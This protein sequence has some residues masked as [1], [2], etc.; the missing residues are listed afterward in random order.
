MDVTTHYF[1]LLENVSG[2]SWPQPGQS[3]QGEKAG[4]GGGWDEEWTVPQQERFLV[5]GLMCRQSA[6]DL[7]ASPAQLSA[8]CMFVMDGRGE[9]LELEGESENHQGL[10]TC[11]LLAVPLIN[12]LNLYV[13]KWGI[14]DLVWICRRQTVIPFDPLLFPRQCDST[15]IYLKVNPIVLIWWGLTPR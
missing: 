15:L 12:L 3:S 10:L 13:N 1:C 2:E 14:L 5:W 6:L 8:A 7:L 4:W 11:P 9:R